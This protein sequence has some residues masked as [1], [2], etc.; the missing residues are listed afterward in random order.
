MTTKTAFRNEYFENGIDLWMRQTRHLTVEVFRSMVKDVFYRLLRNTPQ[1]SGQAVANWKIS[2][3]APDTSFDP[4]LGDSPKYMLHVHGDQ[5]QGFVTEGAWQKGSERWMRYART[6]ARPIIEKIHYRDRVFITN[7]TMGDID[8]WK[9]GEHTHQGERN[10]SYLAAMQQQGSP[11]YRSL[12]T[13]NKP[14]ETVEESV[15]LT[16]MK[17]ARAHGAYASVGN[18]TLITEPVDISE[19]TFK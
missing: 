12:R 7:N 4:N 10:F 18:A 19:L 6:Q 5:S 16:N 15:M 14:F 9:H 13:V 1:W 2:I 3:G 8:I 11:W 17:Y